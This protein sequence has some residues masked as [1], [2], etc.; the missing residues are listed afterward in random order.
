MPTRYSIENASGEITAPPSKSSMQRAVAAALLAKGRSVIH[1]PSFC[2]DSV[3]AMS[4][5]RS[6]GAVI[7]E[8]QD[9]VEIEGGLLPSERI[10][11]CGE[12][13][14]GI[15]MFSAIA[16]SSDRPITI[17]G[18]GS[19]RKR[20][21]DMIEGPLRE[22]GADVSTNGG[23]LP[24]EVRGPL[25]GGRVVVDGSQS[26]QFLTGLLFA[27]PLAELDSII[28]VVNPS[29][30]P[31]IELTLKVLTHFGIEV[32]NHD[33]SLFRIRGGQ[34]Y[35]ATEYTVEG[36]WS[37]A[38]FLMAIAAAS[39]SITIKNLDSH[40]LQA[41]RK[42]L[43]A[44]RLAGCCVRTLAD[45]VTVEKRELKS[46]TFN[47]ADC[48]DLAPPL[49]VLAAA[50]DGTTVI[51]GTERLAIKESNRGSNLEK[52]LNDL[53]AE[54]LFTGDRLVITGGKRLSH[55]MVHSSGDHRMAMAM[56]AISVITDGGVTVDDVGCISKSYPDF[57]NDFIR[58]GG[59][60]IT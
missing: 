22:L 28:E 30:K 16:A 3:A 34:Q 55:A 41:D 9:F 39:G 56:A 6:L 48:P 42:M 33:F 21:M 26:S 45:T 36:D 53:G 14:L 15:R 7:K 54:V 58:V 32:E 2:D 51:T 47:I 50:C 46:F 17:E 59:S 25:K 5:A 11:N 37:G 10:I 12:S 1:K 52:N 27:L 49:A 40:S 38:S 60:I 4:M 24:V 29:S 19:L 44:L 23:F 8:N 35:R 57:P 20:P 43:E 31:Y 13:G 18:T